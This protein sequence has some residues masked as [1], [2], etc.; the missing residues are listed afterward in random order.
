MKYKILVT[1]PALTR[2]GYGE[3]TRLVLR[4]LRQR[5]DMLDIFLHPLN[6]GATGWITGQ[7][8]DREYIDQLV[9]KS[10]VLAKEETTPNFD[11]HI[12]V[13]IPNE[14]ERRAPYSVC[15]TA[16]IET[17][18]VDPK[19]IQK[20]HEID[21][22]IVP[23]EFA[24]WV[25][26][27]TK[28]PMQIE[29]GGQSMVGCGAKVEV[30]H[31]PVRT[32]EKSSDFNIDLEYDNNFLVVAQWSVRKN[33]ENTIRWFIEEFK[34]EE[35]GLVVKANAAKNSYT[36]KMYTIRRFEQLLAEKGAQDRK[37]KIYLLHG[38]LTIEEMNSLYTHK[39]IKGIISATHGEGFG[40]PLFEAAAN[41]L[42]VLAPG[43]SGH[44]DFLYANVRDNK[45]KKNK[46]KALFARVDYVLSPVQKEAVWKDIL[47]EGSMWCFPNKIDFK[48]KLRGLYNN[49]DMYRSWAK[50]LKANILKNFDQKVIYDRMVEA[51]LPAGVL[52]EPDYIFV[53]DA[54][55]SQY[56]GGAEMSL[57]TL[58]DTCP[59]EKVAFI[60]SG[61]LTTELLQKHESSNWVFGNISA[62][63]HDVLR[64]LGE[65]NL[66]YSFIEFDYK[67]CKHRNPLLYSMVE[68]EDCNYSN[69]DLGSLITKFVNNAKSTF[70]MSEKQKEI[71]TNHLS[72]IKQDNMTV[73]SS[74][75]TNEFF[76]YIGNLKTQ[77]KQKSN[78]WV[79]L[80]SNSWVKG[81][82]ESEEWCK[83]NN[84]EYEVLWNV[85]PVEFLNKLAAAKGVCFKP[86]GLDT[87]P[88]FIIEAKL[89]GCELEMNE[90]VQHCDEDW[91]NSSADTIVEYLR[92]R[93]S[94]FWEKSF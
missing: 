19:W 48:R 25:F 32:L 92:S 4:S 12:H 81:A 20:S 18:K 80:G 70:F 10:A 88:R 87:C 91:F 33:L 63:N 73:L 3:H 21:K 57:Q 47:P 79:V 86:T 44:L 1:G 30:V 51:L 83:K 49:N 28:Y 54:F 78:K 67:F 16:G 14:F 72:G 22:I 68:G 27:N 53:S 34:N 6:W 37:C 66:Q 50:K 46:K 26:E 69:T 82:K 89:L 29:D 56:A 85:P 40:L 24:K 45:T 38:D 13:G 93:P 17:T 94:F 59:S 42:P 75:F 31:Y 39:K 84:L 9:A 71:Y 41:G 76:E 15:V 36:D 58:I 64:F 65:S 52:H 61:A 62:L 74:L 11:M 35:V 60:N 7:G 2:S 55:M 23:S 77:V 43:W 90:N 8:E 5:E